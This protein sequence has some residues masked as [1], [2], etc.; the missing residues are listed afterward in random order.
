[1]ELMNGGLIS[2]DIYN[3]LNCTVQLENSINGCDWND[4]KHE[5]LSSLIRTISSEH[6]GLISLANTCENSI[7]TFDSL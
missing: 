4:E 7:L 2:S 6:D 1:M 5:E 3:L